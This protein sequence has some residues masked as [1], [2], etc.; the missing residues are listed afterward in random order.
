MLHK[1]D[2]DK[3]VMNYLIKKKP[4]LGQFYILPKVHKRTFIIPGRPVISNIGTA[5]E[6]KLHFLLDFY[7]KPV[8][9]TIPHILEDTRDFLSRLCYL[10]DIPEN[11][12]V[13][14]FDVVGLYPNIPHE[15][16]VDIMR[17]FLNETRD[18]SIITGS[19]CR[20]AKI[21]LT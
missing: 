17:V 9:Q 6:N 12:I 13:V 7:L 15:E 3:K 11:V 21:V 2:I 10:Q 5:T 1:K 18:K 14:S 8:V 4:Q 20:L 16:G 19:L